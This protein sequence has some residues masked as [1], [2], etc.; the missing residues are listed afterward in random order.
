MKMISRFVVVPAIPTETGPMRNGSRFYCQT[1]P[2]GFNLY[3]NQEKLRLKT[4]YNAREEA[5]SECQRLN[6]ERLQRITHHGQILGPKV[7]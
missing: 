2:I 1:A 6:V 7:K 4:T 5:E 3:D